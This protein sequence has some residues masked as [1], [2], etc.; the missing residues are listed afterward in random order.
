M[1]ENDKDRGKQPE[2]R[3]SDSLSAPEQTPALARTSTSASEASNMAS[4]ATLVASSCPLVVV[5]DSPGC[6]RSPGKNR[7]HRTTVTRRRAACRAAA[8]ASSDESPKAAPASVAGPSGQGFAQGYVPGGGG[9]SAEQIL[10]VPID[11]R[12]FK[13]TSEQCP[14]CVDAPVKESGSK[15]LG[16]CRNPQNVPGPLF[17]PHQMQDV[18][19]AVRLQI[20]AMRDIDEPRRGHGV[21]VGSP[22]TREITFAHPRTT[23]T[24]ISRI[25][26]DPSFV[27]LFTLRGGA[28]VRKKHR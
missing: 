26:Y 20:N 10:E 16:I 3:D 5:V 2:R 14:F 11:R 8:G 13:P 18:E 7:I 15:C 17:Y 9:M 12:K 22:S 1:N 27:P 24:Q 4:C 28:L 25:F 21:Q 19:D 6:R 23:R